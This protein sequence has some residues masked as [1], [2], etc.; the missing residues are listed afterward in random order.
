MCPGS[1]IPWQLLS[2]N[3]RSSV[4][5]FV[6]GS[7]EFGEF[8]I[9]VFGKLELQAAWCGFWS[10]IAGEMQALGG[11]QRG[12]ITCYFPFLFFPFH[13]LHLG[14]TSRCWHPAEIIGCNDCYL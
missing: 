4:N 12:K 1:D 3:Y 8:Q 2:C 13:S 14:D 7:K 5:K 10:L 9:L 11:R 6:L